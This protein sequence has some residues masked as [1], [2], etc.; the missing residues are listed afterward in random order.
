MEFTV[1][2]ASCW[3]DPA[4]ALTCDNAVDCAVDTAPT[5]QTSDAVHVAEGV[6]GDHD[7]RNHSVQLAWK[8]C[9]KSGIGLLL[10]GKTLL[11]LLISRL[12]AG[13]GH[14]TKISL[15]VGGRQQSPGDALASLATVL[16]RPSQTIS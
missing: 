9:R 4:C 2:V 7:D 14:K 10:G 5:K 6:W 15:H 3:S 1:R 8:R 12:H 16:I 11:A 13:V